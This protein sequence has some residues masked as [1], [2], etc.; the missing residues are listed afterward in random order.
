M[1]MPHFYL[2]AIVRYSSRTPTSGRLRQAFV[3]A[4]HPAGEAGGHAVSEAHD[5]DIVRTLVTRALRD[6]HGI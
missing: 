1:T 5:V 6:G 2:T 3:F 4:V